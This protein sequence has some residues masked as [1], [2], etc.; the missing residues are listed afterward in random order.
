MTFIIIYASSHGGIQEYLI[1]KFQTDFQKNYRCELDCQFESIDWSSLKINFKH[2]VIKPEHS[3]SQ[4]W[5]IEADR[6]I[7]SISWWSLLTQFQ[8]KISTSFEHLIA[9]EFYKEGP[10][11]ILNFLSQFFS[12]PASSFI[13]YN[14]FSIVDGLLLIEQ[15]NG[16]KASIPFFCNLSCQR[17]ATRMQLYTQKGY[18]AFQDIIIVDD[19]TGSFLFTIPEKDFLIGF[20]IQINTKLNLSLLEQKGKCCLIGSIKNKYGSFSLK[21][22]DLSF[23]IEPISLQFDSQK[24]L[25][26]S[27]IIIDSSLGNKL[28][29]KDLI[30]NLKGNLQL[31]CHAN[32]YHFFE[33]IKVDVIIQELFYQSKKITPQ[34][35]F[36]ILSLKSDHLT[37]HLE[38]GGIPYFEYKISCQQSKTTMDL[39]NTKDIPFSDESYWKIHTEKCC[40]SLY[41]D[42]SSNLAG[43]YFII[44]QNDKIQKQKKITG[45]LK[46]QNQDFNITGSLDDINYEITLQLLPTLLLKKATFSQNEKTLI[47]FYT[48]TKDSTFPLVGTI[49]F[50]CMQ[51][52]MP[53]Q[54]KTSFSQDGTITLK[55]YVKNGIYYSDIAIKQTNIKIPK[56]YNLIQNIG[57]SC[58]FDLYNRHLKIKNAKVEL[59]EGDIFCSQAHLFFDSIGNIYFIHIPCSLSKVLMSWNKGIFMLISGNIL[60][61]TATKNHFKTNGHIIIEKSQIKE[62]IL[63]AKFQETLFSALLNQEPQSNSNSSHQLAITITTKDPLSIK[64]SFFNAQAK[65]NLFLQ[66]FFNK[67]DLTGVI[68]LLSGS[69]YF[70]YKS[71]DISNGTLFFSSG[72]QFD[73]F[74]DITAK[75]KLKRYGI[76]MHTSGSIFDPSIQFESTPYLTEDQILSLLLL[77]IEESSLSSVHL[78]ALLAQKL[79]EL[80]FGSALS[81]IQLKSKFER[82]LQSLKY[83]RFLPQFTNQTGRGGLRGIFEVDASDHL[84]GKIDVNFMQL[85]DTKFDMDYA[86]TDDI[87]FRAQ[88]DGPSTYGGEVELCWKFN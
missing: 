44:L 9:Q 88:K 52:I 21:N 33:T 13:K 22:D 81:K 76:T 57:A 10:S 51:Y 30:K 19:L 27:S 66:G 71:L 43:S 63:S 64:T 26:D 5:T 32:L 25:F 85:E 17:P 3:T 75:G 12:P 83:F 58:E 20:G 29:I 6:L 73:P 37:G 72:Q 47:D 14:A 49:D 48:D 31:N 4:D 59:Y 69:F 1:K 15:K 80:V 40:F 24:C 36:N 62:N 50:L 68:N 65:L 45:K 55:G 53:E 82:L 34:I 28:P 46:I 8:C 7:I 23:I 54:I 70:P 18:L 35:L 87:T 41:R 2:I 60:L 84:H 61:H 16:I 77:G 67:P 78:P 74:I 56:I 42:Q 79:K 39:F 38:I 11:K 86:I